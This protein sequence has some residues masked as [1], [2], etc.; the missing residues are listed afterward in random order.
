MRWSVFVLT[1]YVICANCACDE[2]KSPGCQE[3]G[4]TL[5]KSEV[6]DQQYR[7]LR[8]PSK[9]DV[10]LIQLDSATGA[11]LSYL[12]CNA[13]SL[14]GIEHRKILR[15]QGKQFSS[16]NDSLPEHLQIIEN[17]VQ[18]YC[19]EPLTFEDG[20]FSLAN[21]WLIYSVTYNDTT[22]FVPCESHPQVPSLTFNGDA[23]DGI[24]AVNTFTGPISFLSG[25]TF[26]LDAYSITLVSGTQAENRFESAVFSAFQSGSIL[27]YTINKNV[28]TLRNDAINYTLILFVK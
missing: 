11:V 24:L 13:Q 27:T 8:D 12:T 10:Y 20:T 26:K 5:Y 17:V 2:E 6:S 3:C 14:K 19:Y 9:T 25:D 28:L 18:D 21:K 1:V 15:I 4:A 7:I 22:L 16:C 23:L